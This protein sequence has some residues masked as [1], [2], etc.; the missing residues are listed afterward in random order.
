MYNDLFSIGKIT[1]HSYGV[2]IA[3]GYVTAILICYFR[4]KK[5]DLDPEVILDIALIAIFGGLGGGKLLYIIVEW[6]RFIEKP[7][8]LLGGD[9]F[10]VYGGIIVAA[11]CAVIYCKIRKVDFLTYFDLVMPAVSVAQA[12]GRLGCFFAGCCYGAP[13][14]SPIGVIFP[15]GSLAPAGIRLWPTQ[16]FSSGGDLI[17]AAILFAVS[18]RKTKKGTVGSLYLVLYGI[19]RFIVEFFRADSRGTVGQLSTSQFISIFIFAIGAILLIYFNF[20][21]NKD[22]DGNKEGKSGKDKKRK[23]AAK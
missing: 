15:S 12:I 10:V 3:L 19:G 16:L 6:K 21:S 9:G 8:A 2:L 1:I 20:L 7:L 18:T 17:I 23:E 13:T 4:A 22:K 14:E 11:V 5:R